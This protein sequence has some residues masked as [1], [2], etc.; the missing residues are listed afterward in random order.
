MSVPPCSFRDLSDE[1]YR[2][3][4]ATRRETRVDVWL[5]T[6]PSTMG[7]RPPWV[8]RRLGAGIAIQPEI[9]CLNCPVRCSGKSFPTPEAS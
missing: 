9:D 8:D 3:D 2:V 7:A 1:A 6:W 5:C 4:M